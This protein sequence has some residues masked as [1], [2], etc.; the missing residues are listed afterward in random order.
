MKTALIAAALCALLTSTAAANDL[1]QQMGDNLAAEP[2]GVF[3][4]AAAY[5]GCPKGTVA[6]DAY[7]ESMTKYALWLGVSSDADVGAAI[8]FVEKD[9]KSMAPYQSGMQCTVAAYASRALLAAGKG[10]TDR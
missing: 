2:A 4:I 1:L 5:H 3:Q 8:E 6:Y 7:R 9:A 10:E